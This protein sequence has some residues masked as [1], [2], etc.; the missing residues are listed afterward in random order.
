VGVTDTTEPAGPRP[1]RRAYLDAGSV[2]PLHPRAREVLLAA[3]DDG[4]ADP[5]RLHHEGRT[6]RLLLDAAR[7]SVAGLLGARPDEVSFTGSHAAAV[8]AGVLGAR[9][10]RRRSGPVTVVSAVEH[11]A[12]L[13]AAGHPIATGSAPDEV[14]VRTVPVDRAGRVDVAGFEQALAGG[15]VAL[16]CLQAANGEVGTVQ[17]VGPVAELCAAAGVPLL[18]D[19]ASSAGHLA[20]PPG[21]SVLTADPRAWG[22]PAG[23]GVLGLRTGTRWTS[24]WPEDDGTEPV[25]G[26]VAIPQA[27]AAAAALAAV[28]GDQPERAARHRLVDRIRAAAAAV[29]DT[30]VAGDPVHRLPHVVT[31]SC[32]YVDGEALVTELDRRGFAVGSGSAC[33]AASLQPSHVLAAMGLLTHG[34]V[35][36]GLPA[37]VDPATV[38]AFCAVLPEA[39]AEVRALL[40]ADDL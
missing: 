19:L 3:L 28:A 1:P 36:V 21:W 38:E 37:G 5:R 25:P 32:L 13:H 15:D 39:V 23:V 31:F 10:G 34:N 6:A 17:P 2:A 18:V 26:A 35:R 11:S 4:W 22:G 16:A 12:V 33:T 29:P 8:A 14:P 24:P 20:V 30:D 40:G 9:A 7:E 27:L